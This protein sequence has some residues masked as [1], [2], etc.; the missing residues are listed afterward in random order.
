MKSVPTCQ[1]CGK[2]LESDDLKG[3]C[4]EC[5][6]KAGFPTGTESEPH[7]MR[8]RF[9][10]PL[11]EQ[12]A[13]RFPQ[14]DILGFIGQGGMGAVYKARQKQLDR[15]VA[16]KI[17]PPEVA[18]GPGFA[19][20]FAREARAMAK[21]NHPRIV[22]LY[23]FGE[24][25]GLY[26]FLMEYV[27]GL[28]LQ[29]LLKAGRITAREALAIVPQICEALEFAHDRGIVHRDIKPGNILLDRQ[30]QVKIADFGIAKIVTQLPFEDS[31]EE[32]LNSRESNI[33]EA[34]K[35]LGTPQYM[36][37]EQSARPLEVDHR[38]DIFSLGVVFYQML[39][40]ELPARKIE[41]PSR[42][43]VID[44]RLDEVV[45]RALERLPD[46][47]YQKASEVRER[48]ETISATKPPESSPIV[49]TDEQQ[50]S[51]RPNKSLENVSFSN[52]S[53]KGRWAVLL[54]ALVFAIAAWS[55]LPATGTS[56]HLGKVIAV[57]TNWFMTGGAPSNYQILLDTDHSDKVKVV[58]GLKSITDETRGFG[59]VMQTIKAVDFAGKQVR[60]SAYVDTDQIENWSGLWVRVDGSKNEMQAFDNMSDRPIK[61]TTP[62][63]KYVIILNVPKKARDI[64]FGLLIEGRGRALMRDLVV[65]TVSNEPTTAPSLTTDEGKFLIN[66]KAWVSGGDNPEDYQMLVARD[67]TT[68]GNISYC[69][70]SVTN[71]PKS[72]GTIM[73]MIPAAGFVGKRIRFAGQVSSEN[74]EVAARLWM[75]VGGPN[76]ESLAFDNMGNKP[77]TGT[78]PSTAYA[79]VLDAPA[80]AADISFGLLVRGKGQAWM[81][82]LTL[83]IVGGDIP[84]TG[85][86][87]SLPS[88]SV[89][90]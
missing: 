86:R 83:E 77:V 13:E 16:L 68:S 78:T 38:A 71:A 51:F 30:G 18:G 24:T 85:Q 58:I 35:V 69:L 29:Q 65:E 90:P 64:S 49:S 36:A 89:L 48:V 72:F 23:E 66:D 59:T 45:L 32:S 19:E 34:G 61:G 74:I 82:D 67:I 47:R 14:L 6:L 28:N 22:T 87:R 57:G 56:T 25:D 15:V 40:G 70:K 88:G 12:L 41:A 75:R 1:G 4:C 10:P 27:D 8:L 2:R 80:N 62:S 46:L 26:F 84:T 3:F 81:R 50:N 31:A 63:T 9:V 43:V 53:S 37:P 55:I 54:A 76:G 52:G 39:T 60:L 11:P 5:L 33:T 21:L 42:K 79:I 7:A 20:R 73:Q 44:V 17:L